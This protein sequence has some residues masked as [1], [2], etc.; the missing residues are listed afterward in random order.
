[1]SKRGSTCV[2][3]SVWSFLFVAALWFPVQA[4]GACDGME[5]PVVKAAPKALEAGNVNLVLIWVQEKDEGEARSAFEKTLAVRK[6]GLEA[7]ALADM[8]FFE[9]VVRIHR[10]G[11]GAPYTGLKPAGAMH[12]EE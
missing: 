11:E 5:G 1:M 12:A 9:T 10:A 2:S 8:Y 3:A 4:F 6:L 7:K